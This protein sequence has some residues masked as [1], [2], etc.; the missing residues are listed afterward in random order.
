MADELKVGDRVRF[1]SAPG[2]ANAIKPGDTG[3]VKNRVYCA[4]DILLVIA[5]HNGE[6]VVYCDRSRVYRVE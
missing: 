6:P 4:G 3:T 1:V 5:P 2:Y